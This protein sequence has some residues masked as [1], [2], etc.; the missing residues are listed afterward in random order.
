MSTVVIVG[1]QWGDEG[2]GKITDFLA[3]QADMVVRCQG[4]SNAGH[5]VVVDGIVHKLHLVPS[6]ILY[7]KVSCIVG[8]GVVLDLKMVL[9]ELERLEA[10]GIDIKNLKISQRVHL[11]MPYHYMMDEME[12]NNKGAKSIGT[13]KRGIGPAYMDKVAR[14]GIRLADLLN[15]PHFEVILADNVKEKN[16]LFKGHGLPNCDLE[17]IKTEF[18]VYA[19]KIRPYVGETLYSLNK[20][21][22]EGKKVLFEGAQGTHLDIDH[23]TYPYVT[24]SAPC[25]GG[26]C[27]GSGVGP[28]KINRVVGIAKS[29]T[30]RVGSGPFPG[31]LFDEVGEEIRQKGVE[32][33]TTT[34]RPRRCGWQDAVVL[35]YSA[36]VNGLT[37]LVIT[38]LDVLDEMKEV[39]I[40]RAYAYKGQEITEFPYDLTVLAECEPIYEVLPGWQKDTTGCRSFQELPA[41]AQAFIKRI[42][43]LAGVD[44][45]IVA[46]GPERSQTIVCKTIF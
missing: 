29:Y 15:W 4:G 43:E 32:F 11:I 9:Q 12:E 20:A 33:G 38:K 42:E 2:K 35:R 16:I 17:A 40:C 37:D 7:P 39:K 30:T 22:E 34:G 46:V 27:T 8:N 26:A 41:E 5:T 19:Q 10:M 14:Q 44:V 18:A 24:S 3:A 13:T 31:E 28:T 21:I 36:V 45:A 1:A 6:G 23:G 25:A